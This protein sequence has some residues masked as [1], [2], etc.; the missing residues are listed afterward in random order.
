MTEIP[1]DLA[2]L[3][4]SI[5][6]R[7]RALTSSE[8]RN[9]SLSVSR[10]L[11]RLGLLRKGRRIA[12]Y[13]AIDGEIDL[14]PLVYHA[15]RARCALYA[16]QIVDMQARKMEF[17][18]LKRIHGTLSATGRRIP[19]RRLDV[20]V[21]PLVAFDRYGHRLGFGAGFYDR[22]LSFMRLGRNRKPLLIGVAFDFQRIRNFKPNPWDVS[23]HLVATDRRLYR[24]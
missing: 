18:A 19:P 4:S 9:A 8:R 16:P 10:R 21:V 11:I 13:N 20:I 2:A 3:R 17:R 1:L 12:V 6:Q 15:Q 14:S 5:R 23:L 24:C 22:K 7:R